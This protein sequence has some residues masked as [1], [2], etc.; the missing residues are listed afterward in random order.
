MTDGETH[1]CSTPVVF[2]RFKTCTRPS[3]STVCASWFRIPLE[4]SQ[5]KP[6]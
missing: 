5:L 2:S 4:P 3:A 6:A 1:H